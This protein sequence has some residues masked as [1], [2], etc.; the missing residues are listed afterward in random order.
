MTDFYDRDGESLTLFEWADKHENDEYK[1]V[2]QTAIDDDIRVSTV[3]LGLD[4]NF[5]IGGE[6]LIFE[7]MIFGGVND[8]DM[9]R[10]STE[11][12]A[13]AGHEVAVRTVR[14]DQADANPECPACGEPDKYDDHIHT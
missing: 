10:Y 9:W 3:W 12:E 11:A 6:P 13:R 4:H 14:R 7:T 2:T 8:M 5:A 1:I